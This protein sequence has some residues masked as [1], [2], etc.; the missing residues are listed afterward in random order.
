MKKLIKEAVFEGKIYL[1]KKYINLAQEKVTEDFFAQNYAAITEQ[2]AVFGNGMPSA[3]Y[4]DWKEDG[5]TTDMAIA[6]PVMEKPKQV[7]KGFE[8]ISIAPCQCFYIDYY[9]SYAQME[10][11]HHALSTYLLD[12]KIE[13]NFVA[14]EEYVTD[15]ATEPDPKN[16]L[17]RIS[18][19]KL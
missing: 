2:K 10:P 15:P 13:C 11:A 7:N 16:W 8:I 12:N 6:I 17:T 3:L 9:G 18:Y 4:F 1:V 5:S 14:I 19:V